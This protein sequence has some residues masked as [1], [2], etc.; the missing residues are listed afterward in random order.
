MRKYFYLFVLALMPMCFAACGGDDEASGVASVTTLYGTWKAT[1]HV[2]VFEGSNQHQSEISDYIAE[3]L[4]F[5]E[6]GICLVHGGG[7]GHFSSDGSYAFTFDEQ[8]TT[9]RIGSRIFAVDALSSNT[10]KLKEIYGQDSQG[11][12]EYLQVTYQ[13][14]SDSVWENL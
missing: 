7:R 4:H 14:V 1:N 11:K 3:Y 12:E 6:D 9:L 8:K 5:G 13:K 2:A 10:L